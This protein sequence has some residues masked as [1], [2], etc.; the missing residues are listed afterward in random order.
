MA[1]LAE[2]WPL[3]V[4]EAGAPGTR[5]RLGAEYQEVGLFFRSVANPSLPFDRELHRLFTDLRRGSLGLELSLGREEDDVDD[6]ALLTRLRNDLATL[7]LDYTPEGALDEQGRPVRWWLGQPSLTLS[8][9]HAR[10]ETVE[11]AAL[12]FDAPVDQRQDYTRVGATFRHET[13]A[14]SVGHGRGSE[15]DLTGAFSDRRTELTDAAMTW[16]PGQRFYVGLQGQYG[17]VSDVDLGQTRRSVL[18]ALNSELVLV[19]DRLTSRFNLNLNRERGSD[20]TFDMDTRTYSLGF[21][22]RARQP[23]AG[24]PGLDLWLRG[25]YQD[26]ERTSGLDSGDSPYQ[27]F[28]GA[29]LVWPVSYP[30][31]T[32]GMQ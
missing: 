3:G 28:V 20:D 17:T 8:S 14:W 5:W 22:W 15:N 31:A 29:T 2:Y 23:S 21:T 1:L 9:Q 11:P 24:R 18:A 10:R 6:L 30:P 25:E 26:I 27:L 16:Q 12:Q 13:F 7:A 32:W 4:P 19:P